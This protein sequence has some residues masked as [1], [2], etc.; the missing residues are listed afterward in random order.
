[1]L[2]TPAATWFGQAADLPDKPANVQIDAW[3]DVQ[4]NMLVRLKLNMTEA[5]RNY[6]SHVQGSARTDEIDEVTW[7]FD[8]GN[9]RLNT[10]VPAETFVFKAPANAEPVDAYAALFRSSGGAPPTNDEEEAERTEA[11]QARLPYPAPDFTLPDLAAKKVKLSDFHGKVVLLDF[12]AT[13]CGPCRAALPHIQA[14]HNELAEKGLQILAI[15]IGEDAETVLEFVERNKMSLKVLLDTQD[16]S[17][18]LYKVSAI[19]KTFLIDR[20]G[21]VVQIYTGFGPGREAELREQIES[22]LAA[23]PATQDAGAMNPAPAAP[24]PTEAPE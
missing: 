11:E 21:K 10:P 23:T 2:V 1:M 6:F 7:Q 8:A 9:I 16:I 3:F 24:E 17:S 19:P 13:W 12:W 18:T 20:Q 4:T 22:L 5:M 15:A 14:L